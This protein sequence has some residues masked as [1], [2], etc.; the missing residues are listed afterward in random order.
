MLRGFLG[1]ENICLK[2]RVD[3]AFDPIRRSLVD[4]ALRVFLFEPRVTQTSFAPLSVA[5]FD[6]ISQK[7]VVFNAKTQLSFRENADTYF[8]HIIPRIMLFLSSTIDV[9][10]EKQK[11]RGSDF[12]LKGL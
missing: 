4:P 5:N 7:N 1:I 6:N 10:A 2:S 11:S 9:K 8:F 3:K 12:E